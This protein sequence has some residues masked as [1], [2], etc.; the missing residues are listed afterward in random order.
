MSHRIVKDRVAVAG[1]S[2]ENLDLFSSNRRPDSSFDVSL[3]AG[4][5][6]LEVA[7]VAKA[8]GDD[9]MPATD[10]EKHAHDLFLGPPEAPTRTQLRSVL[11][12]QKT[13]ALKV[14]SVS[15]GRA[16]VK[17]ESSLSSRPT[18]SNSATSPAVSTR[19]ATAFPTARSSSAL[20]KTTI[21]S[22]SASASSH[23]SPPSLPLKS[24]LS[25]TRSSTPSSVRTQ[26]RSS[27]PSSVR[28][29]SS[30][31][32][33]LSVRTPS[34]S[35]TPSSRTHSR[36]AISSVAKT[37]SAPNSRSSTPISR[38]QRAAN[39][40]ATSSSHVLTRTGE[41][42]TS[43][44]SGGQRSVSGSRAS[45]AGQSFS[46]HDSPP[47]TPPRL[48]ATASTPKLSASLTSKE[49]RPALNAARGRSN[50]HDSDRKDFQKVS[51]SVSRKASGQ[52]SAADS[53][54]SGRTISK[55]SLQTALKY[56]DIQNGNVG[57]RP[58]S[59]TK[60]YPHS[61]K[62]SAAAS[63]GQ[64][65]A[66]NRDKCSTCGG[67]EGMISLL[68]KVGKGDRYDSARYETLLFGKDVKDTNW[69]LSIDEPSSDSD[70][71]L[72]FDNGFEPPPEPFPPL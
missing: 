64:S 40:A 7:K 44:S 32:T 24:V 22:T 10:R 48:K 15:N 39:L 38:P 14:R 58:F 5:D 35:S 11:A 46:S 6:S 30:S 26:S 31:S 18:R 33:P 66:E 3:K 1:D 29:Q 50:G 63:K 45:S 69:L 60:L 36:S 68:A 28:T 72:L 61:I 25:V 62:S 52:S 23:R 34:R 37:R 20:K 49:T 54:G 21:A 71:S 2:D 9:L 55:F 13:T 70:Q 19:Q 57:R 59:S 53:S 27:T 43:R 42:V 17:T 16:A 41:S 56:M 51:S 12:A 67:D 4:W 47:Q 65:G 8:G